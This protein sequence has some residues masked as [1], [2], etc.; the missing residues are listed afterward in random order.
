MKLP[1]R[2]LLI[3]GGLALVGA[4]GVLSYG[5]FE[6]WRQFLALDAIRSREFAN[7]LNLM[8]GGAALALL[9]GLITGYALGLPRKPKELA[10]QRPPAGV[11]GQAGPGSAGGTTA[12]GSPARPAGPTTHDNDLR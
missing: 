6:V 4:I 8:V 1:A 5:G 7:P 3:V 10:G 11:G 9:A 12:G 2:I